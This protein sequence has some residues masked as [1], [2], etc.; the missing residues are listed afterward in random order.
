MRIAVVI[1]ANA[2]SLIGGLTAQALEEQLAASRIDVVIEPDDGRALPD[3][4][5]AAMARGVDAV[6]VAGGDGTI[7]CGAQMLAGT[8]TA[9]GILPLGTMNML[10]KDI[11]IPID[12]PAAIEALA[13]GV[14]RDI[15]V[16]EVNGHV[17]LCN[18]VLGFASRLGVR[19]E[20]ARG[21]VGLAV[22][23]RMAVVAWR[24]ARRYPSMKLELEIDGTRRRLRT[25]SVAVVDNDYGEAPGKLFNRPRLDS[26]ELVLYVTERM[27]PWR[28]V[29]LAFG[30]LIGRWRNLP[31]L[32]RI[33]ATDFVIHSRHKALR[34]MNDGE[35]L[36]LAPPLHYRIRPKALKVIVPREVLA[37]AESAAAAG[38]DA[39]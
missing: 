14:E 36:L 11:G 33:V 20:R 16:G 9:F 28:L 3:R 31:G 18:S 12:L 30:F 29:S 6:A 37:E 39:A 13:D 35:G 15:D 32:T 23:W 19:R 4:I 25:R 10:A 34:V 38:R 27:T 24:S 22:I 8:G 5:A 26:G 1:N 21:K 7:A 17:F 2:G